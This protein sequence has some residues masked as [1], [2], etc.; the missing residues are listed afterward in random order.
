MAQ[1][2]PARVRDKDAKRE[3]LS[4]FFLPMRWDCTSCRWRLLRW[5]A[6]K[7][8]PAILLDRRLLDRLE[9]TPEPAE[10]GSGLAITLDE[11]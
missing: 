6:L 2:D 4:I 5:R 7:T 8:H 3:R 10:L 9:L 1:A 11:E